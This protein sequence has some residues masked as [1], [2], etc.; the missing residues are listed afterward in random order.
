MEIDD[1]DGQ[2][3][4]VKQQPDAGLKIPQILSAGRIRSLIFADAAANSQQMEP[5]HFWSPSGVTNEKFE[6]KLICFFLKN[7]KAYFF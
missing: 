1:L 2:S 7:M 3:R 6:S 5:Q 4:Q